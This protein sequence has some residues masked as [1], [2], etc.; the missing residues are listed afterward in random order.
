VSATFV[1]FTNPSTSKPVSVNPNHVR[2]AQEVPGH[3]EWTRLAMGGEG[4]D[5]TVKGDL[6]SVLETLTGKTQSQAHFG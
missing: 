2:N 5:V 1:Q 3:P 4:Q 6:E